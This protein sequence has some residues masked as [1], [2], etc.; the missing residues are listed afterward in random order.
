MVCF[1]SVFLAK[2]GQF[3]LFSKTFSSLGNSWEHC[4][5]DESLLSAVYILKLIAIEC[6]V[7]LSCPCVDVFEFLLKHLDFLGVSNFPPQSCVVRK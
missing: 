3:S 4:L 2:S 7:V 1:W 5:G 6:G